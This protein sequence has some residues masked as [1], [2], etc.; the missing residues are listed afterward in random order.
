MEKVKSYGA[1]RIEV[2]FEGHAALTRRIVRFN[3]SSLFNT[4]QSIIHA[5]S[6]S[7]LISNSPICFS[8]QNR[9]SFSVGLFLDFFPAFFS[10]KLKNITVIIPQITAPNIAPFQSSSEGNIL[11]VCPDQAQITP[12]ICSV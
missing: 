2:K 12:Q 7:K 9:S 5:S 8:Y 4:L 10:H 6:F 11:L 3:K 1:A